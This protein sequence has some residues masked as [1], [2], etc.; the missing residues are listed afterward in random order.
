M[1][2][3]WRRSEGA[4]PRGQSRRGYSEGAHPRWANPSEGGVPKALVRDEPSRGGQS[5]GDVPRG[6]CRGSRSEMSRA[7]GAEPRDQ[8]RGGRLKGASLMEL[9]RRSRSERGRSE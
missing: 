4:D 5:E 9:F 2:C 7:E 1:P 8:I 3:R 6:P